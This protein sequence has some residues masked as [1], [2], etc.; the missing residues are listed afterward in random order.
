MEAAV[1]ESYVG[2]TRVDGKGSGADFVPEIGRFLML[3]VYDKDEADD[4]S[5]E[6]RR[7]LA[8]LA[9]TYRREETQRCRRS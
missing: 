1:C 8:D 9:E 2:A 6:E 3:D 7:L 5:H 4:L